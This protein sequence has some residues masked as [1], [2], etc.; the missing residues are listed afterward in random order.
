MRHGFCWKVYVISCHKST[1]VWSQLTPNAMTIPCHLSRFYLFIHMPKHDM[2]FTEVQVMKFPWHSLRKWWNFPCGF[3]V[4]FDQAAVKE[5]WENQCHIFYR[6]GMIY[7]YIVNLLFRMEYDSLKSYILYFNFTFHKV[8]KSFT[9]MM[10]AYSMCCGQGIRLVFY[11]TYPGKY[12]AP[13]P[14]SFWNW[15]LHIWFSNFPAG[16]EILI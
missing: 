10:H 14:A 6:G 13:F 11:N 5:T 12:H 1:A 16:Q 3:G 4:I 7:F 9:Q 8:I 2:D 15:M